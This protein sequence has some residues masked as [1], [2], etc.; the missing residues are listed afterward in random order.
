MNRW[1]TVFS[2]AV[3]GLLLAGTSARADFVQWTYNWQPGALE[4]PADPGGTGGVSFSNQPSAA[5]TGNSDI[6]ATNLRVFSS[7]TPSTPDQLIKGGAYSLALT[8]TDVASGVSGTLTWTGKLTGTFSATSS[9]LSNAFT[10]PL[11]QVI[12]LGQNVYTV[13]IG[14]YSPPGPPTAGNAGSI[15]AHVNVAPAGGTIQSNSP[16]PSTLV[17]AGLALTLGGGAAWRKRRASLAAQ[18]A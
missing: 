5:A 4:A 8:L 1:L 6:V 7:A 13:T 9:N 14:Q 3:A 12:Q 2:S 10:S 18:L 16:E 11:T 15:G 17:L